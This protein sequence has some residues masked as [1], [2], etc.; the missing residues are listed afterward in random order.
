MPHR[1]GH[2]PG[3]HMGGGA[4]RQQ[5]GGRVVSSPS[6]GAD[7]RAEKPRTPNYVQMAVE[8][9]QLV[10]HDEVLDDD[11]DSPTYDTFISV[12]Y[13]TEPVE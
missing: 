5:T 9:G 2:K 3:A 10:Y 13:G 4:Y 8:S 7:E 1:S 12:F 11:E 6:Q